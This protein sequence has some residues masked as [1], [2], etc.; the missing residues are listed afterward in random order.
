MVA[1]LLLG[2]ALELFDPKL[3]MFVNIGF[4][5]LAALYAVDI[6]VHTSQ[7]AESRIFGLLLGIPAFVMLTIYMFLYAHKLGLRRT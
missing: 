3:A 7:E 2:V 1:I 5:F 6:L 4:F